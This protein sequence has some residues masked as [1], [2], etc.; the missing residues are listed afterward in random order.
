VIP[1]VA[2][3]GPTG[4]GKTAVGIAVAT[5]CNA[6]I[7]NADSRQV[8]R[9]LDIGSAKPTPAQQAAVAHHVIDVAEPDEA[10]DC[11]RF[12]ELAT[13]AVHDIVARGKRVLV[14][15]GTGLY[16]KVLLHGL[17]AAP[18]RD[19][20]LRAALLEAESRRPGTLHRRLVGVDPTTAAR[21]HPHDRVR[22]V[23]AL[24][25]HALTAR[26]LSAWQADHRF[27]D[28]AF[29]ALTIGLTLPRPDLYA[30]I[31]ARCDTMLA[32]GLVAEV[33]SLLAAGF[34]P[35]L[36]ALCSPG[37]REISEYV[38]DRCDLPTA[39][40]RMARATRRLAKRQL[41]WFCA[42]PSTRWSAPEPADVIAA[43]TAFWTAR[44]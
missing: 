31:D 3:V 23:R 17:C 10:F 4:V 13:A 38:R 32:D 19:A 14:V 21:L 12:R 39:V 1:L 40:A 18:P 25:V 7:V 20:A 33:R 11:A 22:L 28:R 30:R 42:A 27:A 15:G 37:Y 41:T 9:R 36:P 26:P 5:A 35:A 34:D 8:Y 43:A 29:D 2:L 6:E 44:G 24:E 16:V